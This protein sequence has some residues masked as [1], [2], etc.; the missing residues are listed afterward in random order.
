M[1][2]LPD[3]SLPVY[4]LR[5]VAWFAPPEAYACML[6]VMWRLKDMMHEGIV[7]GGIGMNTSTR[8]Q[9][10]MHSNVKMAD[11]A[12]VGLET[13]TDAT[14]AISGVLVSCYGGAVHHSIKSL[15]CA[16]DCTQWAEAIGTNRGMVALDVC[17]AI[18]RAMGEDNGEPAFVGTDNLSN[19]LVAST[20]GTAKAARHFIRKY[21]T[22]MQRVKDGHVFIGHVTDAENPADMLTKFVSGKKYKASLAYIANR[23]AWRYPTDG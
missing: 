12:P 16:V 6:G 21:W 13:M 10:T 19:A 20:W 11:G 3:I 1:S 14:Y 7:F 2:V 5:C 17:Q 4:R 9:G 22:V 15:G 18:Q 23:A 8:P